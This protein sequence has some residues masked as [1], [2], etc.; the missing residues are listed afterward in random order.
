MD[1]GRT[2]QRPVRTAWSSRAALALP[3]APVLH[4]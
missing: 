2:S 4:P 3:L 1:L